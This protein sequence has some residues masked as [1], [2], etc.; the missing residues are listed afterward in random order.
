MAAPHANRS[1]GDI[2]LRWWAVALPAAAFVALLMLLV[3]GTEADAA[4]DT[5]WQ[6]V[7]DLVAHVHA[8]LLP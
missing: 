3:S 6:P 2:R 5:P 7:G 4:T 1:T 8:A